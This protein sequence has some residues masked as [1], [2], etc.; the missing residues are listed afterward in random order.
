[1]SDFHQLRELRVEADQDLRERQLTEIRREIRTAPRRRVRMGRYLAAAA[2]V[3]IPSVA[4]ASNGSLPGEPLYPIKLL[5]EPLVRVFD[6]HVVADHRIDEVEILIRR[7]ADDAVIRRQ[8]DIARVEVDRI[9][10]EAVRHRLTDRLDRMVRDMEPGTTSIGDR[11]QEQPQDR[12][13]T[14]VPTDVRPA[15]T[16]AP[17]NDPP[18]ADG[19]RPTETT[20]PAE[21]PPATDAP[22]ATEVRSGDRAGDG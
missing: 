4:I 17:A 10:D 19:E 18:P 13:A 5:V 11:P 3:T 1:M 15:E 6:R 8:I 16:T 7:G 21:N 12:P 2:I 20:R 14:T 22:T 9:G